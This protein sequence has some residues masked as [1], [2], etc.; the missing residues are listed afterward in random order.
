MWIEGWFDHIFGQKWNP[1]YCLG[2]L[3]YYY[4]WI[5]SI[6]GIYVYIF[7]DTGIPA[8]FLSV[9]YL[10][11][12]QWW[13][14]GIMRSLH[15]YASDAM[16]AM[17]VLHIIREFAFDRYRG[18]RW[19]SWI[20][21]IP[22]IWLIIIAGM[23]GYWLVWD[24][25]AQYVGES[26][27]ELL[28]WIPIFG[29]PI[30]RN[31]LAP[32]HIDGRFFTLMTFTHI[33]VP[34]FLLFVM[35]IHLQRV[36][37][38]RINPPRGLAIGTFIMLMVLSLVVPATSQGVA[39]LS[40]APSPVALDWFYL[41][42]FPLA[43]IFGPGMV[44]GGLFI[45]SFLLLIT[46]WLPPA[47]KVTPAIVD[48]GNCN[49]CTRCAVDCPFNA[50]AMVKRSDGA[51]FEHEAVV[52]PDVCVACGICVGSCPTATP[53]RRAGDLVPGIDLPDLSLATMR[54]K[55]DTA[56]AKLEGPARLMV[57][58]CDKALKVDKF[59]GK[60]IATISMPCAGM[61][62]PSFID[63]VLSKKMTDGVVVTGCRRGE[64]HYRLGQIWLEERLDGNRDPRLRKRVPRDRIL[65]SW[66]SA[67]DGRSFE[68]NITK[69]KGDIELL[70]PYGNENPTEKDEAGQ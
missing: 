43:D 5:V 61:L 66:A 7:F 62:P 16:V 32:S 55:V 4:F 23:T 59:R 11:N 58:G 64:C 22:M 10:T 63:Y 31:F 42:V 12:E 29:E 24:V 9:E 2:A 39:D 48:L 20:T 69:F 54:E 51:A 26:T 21:G 17:M 46:P 13:L 19:F 25:L 45:G 35:W 34:L 36:A 41:W 67:T 33:F 56:T 30:A 44:W 38:S 28:D 1:T 65:R 6:S 53:F 40:V 70:G 18:G 8:A 3:G 68:K 57:F 60:D 47:K 49:G 37:H 15:R 27:T 52:D 14:G 50:I